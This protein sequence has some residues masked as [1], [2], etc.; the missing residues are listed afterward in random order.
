MQELRQYEAA[1]RSIP[2]VA[3]GDGS[4]VRDARD[5][6]PVVPPGTAVLAL[7]TGKS[8]TVLKYPLRYA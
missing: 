1:R 7:S 2:G 3:V 5:L 8:A 6:V 4:A